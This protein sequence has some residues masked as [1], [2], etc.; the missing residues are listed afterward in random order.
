MGQNRRRTPA[1][2]HRRLSQVTQRCRPCQRWPNREVTYDRQCTSSH[3]ASTMVWAGVSANTP[4]PLVFV[5]NKSVDQKS[6]TTVA[7][8]KRSRLTGLL[9]TTV[10]SST[11]VHQLIY[12]LR[13][14]SESVTV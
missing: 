1:Y 13:C 4:I 11:T 9:E 12:R 7:F 6:M 5:K 8:K 10:F 14:K 2:G 3:P